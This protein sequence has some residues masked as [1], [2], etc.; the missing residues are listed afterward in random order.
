MNGFM[1]QVNCESTRLHTSLPIR[2]STSLST[3][4]HTRL[5]IRLPTRLSTSLPTRLPTSLPTLRP[6][7]LTL[8]QAPCRTMALL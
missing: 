5:P 6:M 3:S 4:L 8:H 1:Q 2:L 7:H